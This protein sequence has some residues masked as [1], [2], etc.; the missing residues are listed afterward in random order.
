MRPSGSSQASQLMAISYL[1]P[2]IWQSTASSDPLTLAMIVWKHLFHGSSIGWM[3][4]RVYND[5]G[6]LMRPSG[7][8]QASELMA[9]SY[10]TL[11]VYN[12]VGDLMRP[13]GSSQASQLMAISYLTP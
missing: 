9:I 2:S 3:Y 4:R 10:L 8:S 11:R 7:S 13:S 1:T 5:V 12:D 6:D